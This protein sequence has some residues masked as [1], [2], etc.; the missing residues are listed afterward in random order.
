MKTKYVVGFAF[1]PDLKRVVLIR[2][3]RP[4]WQ[5]GKLNGVGGHLEVGET[6][7][8]AMAREFLEETGTEI[9]ASD[10]M[11][12]VTLDFP[13]AVL[14]VFFTVS[15]RVDTVQTVESE[16]VVVVNPRDIDNLK[17][18]SNL[19]WLIPMALETI[20]DPM[21]WGNCLIDNNSV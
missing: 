19:K 21:L 13:E 1:S 16:E 11:Y 14:H 12:L 8:R 2:K 20:K 4:E 15:E 3:N 7:H 10:W 18:I 5:R 17:C 6:P 9:A